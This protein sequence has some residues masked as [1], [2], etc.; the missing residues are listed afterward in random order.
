MFERTCP[1]CG[2]PFETSRRNYYYCSYACYEQQAFKERSCQLCGKT[3]TGPSWKS[4]CSRE[5]RAKSSIRSLIDETRAVI[6]GNQPTDWNRIQTKVPYV[7]ELAAI[8]V[9]NIVHPGRARDSELQSLLAM[10]SRDSEF[11]GFLEQSPELAEAY[12]RLMQHMLDRGKTQPGSDAS[13]IADEFSV[14]ATVALKSLIESHPNTNERAEDPL[15]T[16]GFR[17]GRSL[18]DSFG[19]IITQGNFRRCISCHLVGS[20]DKHF[21]K[22]RVGDS[23]VVDELCIYCD[24]S[25]WYKELRRR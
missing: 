8:V 17:T 12:V 5:C 1:V 9:F 16:S 7:P 15:N 21:R 4:F 22:R 20:G 3:Y 24:P 14:D 18:I 11:I 25:E 6:T 13:D 19:S 10:F 2:R 23:W